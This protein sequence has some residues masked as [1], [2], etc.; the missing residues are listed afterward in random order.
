VEAVFPTAGRPFLDLFMAVWTPGSYLIRE[1]ARHVEGLPGKIAK[2][3]W[4]VAAE[5]AETVTVRYRLYCHEMSVRT[6]W[7]DE[8]FA[9]LN[10]AA[11][12]ISVVGQTANAHEVTIILPPQWTRVMTALPETAEGFIA[13]DYDTLADSPILAG[14]PAVRGF[15]VHGK[16]HVLANEGETLEWDAAR[17]AADVEKIVRY[18]ERMWGSLPYGRFLFLNLIV[19]AAGG[20]EHKNSLCVMTSRWATRTRPAYLQWLG[21]MAHEHFHAWNVKRLRP[22]E[23]GPFDY[24][25]ENYTRSL[26]VAEGLTEYYGSL[27][28]RRAGLAAVDEYL[29]ALS[30][31]VEKLQTAPGRLEM[32]VESAS[33]DTWIK[34]YRPDENS[35]NSSISYYTKGGVIAWLLD[36]KIRKATDN[37][38]SLD[39]VVR[40]AYLRFSGDTGFTGAQF[41]ETAREV[42]GADLAAWFQQTLETASELDYSEALDWFGLRFKSPEASAKSTL[43][44]VTRNDNGRMIVSQVP[45]GTAAYAAGFSADDEILA[46]DGFRV[47]PEQWPQRMEQYRP[48]EK[49]GILVAR[50]ER[51]LSIDAVMARERGNCYQLEIAPGAA[52]GRKRNLNLWLA[53]A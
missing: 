29:G 15:E 42:A 40:L 20:L 27:N 48:G 46:I 53:S 7:V 52:D 14:N 4:R 41:R 22:V 21:L 24:E 28:V 44:F 30:E 36:A 1:F 39:D 37:A 19:E 49:I 31:L 2:N 5:G 47:R 43:G 6:N 12:F 25:N 32:P 16:P 38:R 35:A 51:L 17:A 9:F 33:F 11:T 23:L 13:A 18:H 34:L 50:R 26:W 3:R 45:R 10:G 8:R